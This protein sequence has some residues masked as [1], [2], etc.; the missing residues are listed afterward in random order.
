MN[1]PIGNFL[2]SMSKQ[3]AQEKYKWQTATWNDVQ[4]QYVN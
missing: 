2:L 3:F 1:N 4:S